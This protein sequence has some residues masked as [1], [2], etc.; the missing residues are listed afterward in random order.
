MDLSNNFS[1]NVSLL[2]EIHQLTLG[3]FAEEANVSRAHLQ[4]ILKGNCNPT[5][6]T[7][8]QVA[9]GL[10]VDP[11]SLLLDPKETIRS[12]DSPLQVKTMRKLRS[13]LKAASELLDAI[14]PEDSDG[15]KD[16]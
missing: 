13:H 3:E 10:Q 14:L 8:E 16:T 9:E 5:L 12:C 15:S 7:V 6:G 11:T 1:K 4:S 2:R